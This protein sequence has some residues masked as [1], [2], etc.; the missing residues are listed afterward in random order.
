MDK[1]KLNNSKTFPPRPGS[2]IVRMTRQRRV[3]L[4]EM[5]TPGRHLTADMVYQ[6]VRRQLPNISLGT[7]YR[8]LEILMRAGLIKQVRVGCGPKLYDG[9]LHLHYHVRCVKCDKISDVSA[10]PFGNLE[11]AAKKGCEF[12]IL[13]HQLDFEGL[14]PECRKLLKNDK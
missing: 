2:G 1:K 6:R 12:E 11:A 5:K 3:I 7:V 14:C 4:E 9:G 13:D 8:N 10:E